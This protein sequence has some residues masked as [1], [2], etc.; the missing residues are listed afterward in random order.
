MTMQTQ[1]QQ[2]LQ[3]AIERLYTVFARYSLRRVVE[4]C[5]HC[6]YAADNGMLHAAPLR[7]LPRENL[8][9]YAWKAMT[10]WGDVDDFKHFLPRILELLVDDDYSFDAEAFG[11]K[12]PYAEYGAWPEE[13]RLA[14][15]SFCL[16]WW[17]VLLATFPS[18][19]PVEIYLGMFAQFMDD[20]RPFLE[21]V[22]DTETSSAQRHFTQLCL[23]LATGNG[24]QPLTTPVW[25]EERPGQWQQ[26]IDWLFEPLTSLQL[27]RAIETAEVSGDLDN[28]YTQWLKEV[29]LGLIPQ[30]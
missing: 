28:D 12:F 20:I 5:P 1:E 29:T 6:V 13:E 26:F 23:D 4:G 18:K 16:A 30:A 11:G 10:T 19:R 2:A 27:R 21:I 25:W 7:A 17:H 24:S 15:E 22:R 14:V 3:Q 8:K 9:K